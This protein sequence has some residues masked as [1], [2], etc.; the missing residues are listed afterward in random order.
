MKMEVD[1][2]LFNTYRDSEKH[3]WGYEL[4]L[5]NSQFY[6]AKLL[7]FTTDK[8]SSKHY[9]KEKK[10]T[11]IVLLGQVWIAKGDNT[12]LDN[13]QLIEKLYTPPLKVYIHDNMVHQFHAVPGSIILEVSTHHSS[14]DTYR[15]VE[16]NMTISP[17]VDVVYSHVLEKYVEDELQRR[18]MDITKEHYYKISSSLVTAICH[19]VYLTLWREK[20]NSLVSNMPSTI[21]KDIDDMLE[22]FGYDIFEFPNATTNFKPVA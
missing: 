14:N 16:N 21:M 18:G 10:E 11:F 6:C 5:E 8:Y 2:D 3:D 7:V 13:K 20:Y 9:H 4:I 15:I 17:V 12:G 19:S 1:L 22:S